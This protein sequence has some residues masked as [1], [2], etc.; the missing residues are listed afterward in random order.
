[1]TK[2]VKFLLF[3]IVSFSLS[4]NKFNGV[5]AQSGNIPQEII[6][7]V[8]KLDAA[9]NNRDVD[10]IEKYVSSNFT[11]EDG[12]NYET[13]NESLKKLWSKYKDLQY[14][15]T[16][17]SWREENNQ[18]VAITVTNITGSYKINGQKFEL[19]SE[20]KSEQFF[21]DNQLIKQNILKERNEVTSGENPPTVT[22]NL[23]ERVRPG[24]EFDLDVIIEEPVGSDLVLGAA[25]EEEINYSL[26]IEPSSLEL[27]AL[28]AGGIFKRVTLPSNAQDHWYSLILIRNGGIRMITQRVNV[29]N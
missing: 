1:M 27:E 23:P 26:Y 17:E 19:N 22:L 25:L 13:F 16:V 8:P 2:T 14:T 24:Q 11:N 29:D 10:L 18:L 21:A 3:L 28:T 12:L 20:I 9:F 6:E 4:V 7:I 5:W 15:T